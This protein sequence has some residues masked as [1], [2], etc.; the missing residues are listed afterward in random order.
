MLQVKEFSN[1]VSIE[2]A[3]NDWLKENKDIKITDIKYSSDAYNSSVL[4]VYII[5]E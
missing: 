4:I 5:E 2:N 3:M 1:E